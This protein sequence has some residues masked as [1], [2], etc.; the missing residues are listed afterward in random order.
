MQSLPPFR[1]QRSP[2]GV[3]VVARANA[4]EPEPASDSAYAATFCFASCGKYFFWIAGD[5]QRRIALFTRVF[6]TSTTTAQA[7]STRASASMI[8]MDVV[9]FEPRPPYSSGISIPMR[10][11]SK[12]FRMRSGSMTL[13][14]SIRAEWGPID[15]TAKSYTPSASSRSWS[16]RTETGGIAGESVVTGIR[17]PPGTENTEKKRGAEAPRSLERGETG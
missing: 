5:A 8:A 3:A 13:S 7:A 4:S 2:F 14:R 15:S 6:W 16:P 1:S 12:N 11:S 17:L 10:S 9:K